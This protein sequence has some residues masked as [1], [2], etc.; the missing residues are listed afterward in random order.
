MS[1]KKA[2]KQR[3]K[4]P[5]AKYAPFCSKATQ[6]EGA[7]SHKRFRNSFRA[8]SRCG[9]SMFLSIDF[10]MRDFGIWKLVCVGGMD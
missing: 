4:G 9:I 8:H 1:K 7:A 3:N 6:Y 2:K 10:T 5:A